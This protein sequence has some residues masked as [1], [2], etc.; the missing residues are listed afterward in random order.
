MLC[1]KKANKTPGGE[2]KEIGAAYKVAAG[3]VSKIEAAPESRP[4]LL[5]LDQSPADTGND[6]QLDTDLANPL[7]CLLSLQITS[8]FGTSIWPN[9][10]DGI[11]KGSFFEILF[12]HFPEVQAPGW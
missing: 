9:Y 4:W 1:A 11:L 7:D 12:L 8:I 5:L 10:P 6:N 2:D 3:Q